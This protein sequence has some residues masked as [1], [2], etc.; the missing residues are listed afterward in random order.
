MSNTGKRPE[1]GTPGD[2]KGS[3]QEIDFKADILKMFAE[4]RQSEKNLELKLEQV[5]NRIGKMEKKIDETVNEL[6]GQLKEVFRRTQAVEE[7]LKK[8][9]L[10]VKDV[11]REEDKIKAEI[12]DLNKNQEEMKDL[13]A[14][15]ELRQKEVNLRFRA[16]PEV[17]GENIKVKLI[18]ELASWL[19]ISTEEMENAVQS[20]FRM[21]AKSARNKRLVG[22]CLV[23]FK[24]REMR[25]MI[26]Q[27]NKEKRLNIGGNYIII[28]KD[29]PVRLLKRRESY[30]ELVQT[31]KRN[32]I[33][34]K[35]EFPEGISFTYRSKRQK[36]TSPEETSK[37][38]RKYKELKVHREDDMSEETERKEDSEEGIERSEGEEEEEEE[39]GEGKI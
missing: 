22:D 32:N 8:T 17:Q 35:W 34:F 13:I 10:E 25:N 38:L 21:K 18:T 11:R 3:K 5:D 12:L 24:E 7:G 20:A 9:R 16:V 28:F 31:L 19:E 37:F 39:R 6:K 30:K 27:K 15:N 29:I 33:E 36:L 23:I 2:R 26:L 14:M 1:G 4:I